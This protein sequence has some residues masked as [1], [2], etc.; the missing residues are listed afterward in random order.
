MEGGAAEGGVVE[1]E[2]ER[3]EI[4]E[5]KGKRV[6]RERKEMETRSS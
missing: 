3:G 1:R 2:R 5:W 4:G 6:R